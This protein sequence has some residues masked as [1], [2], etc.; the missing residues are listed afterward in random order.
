MTRPGPDVPVPDCI[1]AEAATRF[2]SSSITALLDAEP[3]SIPS[4]YI[5]SPPFIFLWLFCTHIVTYFF[6]L[7]Q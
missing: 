2:P 7:G 5:Q 6:P 1:T 3:T 4:V